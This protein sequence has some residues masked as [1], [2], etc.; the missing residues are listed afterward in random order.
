MVKK[1][2]C[3]HRRLKKTQVVSMGSCQVKNNNNNNK[4]SFHRKLPGENLICFHRKLPGKNL[5]C[6]HRKLPG[7]NLICFHR[8][9]PWGGDSLLHLYK[10]TSFSPFS[11]FL[12]EHWQ[13]FFF[14]IF[15]FCFLY[16]SLFQRQ[17]NFCG[18]HIPGAYLYA[19]WWLL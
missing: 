7:K 16:M 5:I 19:R 4:T 8:K 14:Q 10:Q 9:L 17:G 12:S 3:F 11:R 13:S 2:T 18:V 1:S 15:C 6:F